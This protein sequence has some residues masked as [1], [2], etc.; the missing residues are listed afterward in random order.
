MSEE[1]APGPDV[2]YNLEGKLRFI[3]KHIF[4]LGMCFDKRKKGKFNSIYVIFIVDVY[5]IFFSSLG[6]SCL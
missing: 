5:L 2:H 3:Q 4:D 1:D 6:S